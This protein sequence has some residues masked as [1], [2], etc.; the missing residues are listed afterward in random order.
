MSKDSIHARSAARNRILCAIRVSGRGRQ[1]EIH[2]VISRRPRSYE[3]LLVVTALDV[4]AAALGW[5]L[6]DARFKH[7]VDGGVSP[8]GWPS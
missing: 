3:G 4:Y 8:T 1:R 5:P 7:L 6:R 2:I